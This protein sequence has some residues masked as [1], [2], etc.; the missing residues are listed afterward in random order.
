MM[1]CSLLAAGA[2]A[3]LRTLVEV[4]HTTTTPHPTVVAHVASGRS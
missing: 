3:V 2:A 1:L 4:A